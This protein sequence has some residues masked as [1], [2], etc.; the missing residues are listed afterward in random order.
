MHS[1]GSIHHSLDSSLD[2]GSQGTDPDED[3]GEFS[4]YLNIKR[5]LTLKSLNKSI[6]LKGR[7]NQA[8]Q[9]VAKTY[10]DEIIEENMKGIG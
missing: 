8:A 4:K 6:T 7:R 3:L 5:K 2:S 10:Q 1:F 9:Q